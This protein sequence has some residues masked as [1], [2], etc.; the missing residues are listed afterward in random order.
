[1]VLGPVHFL[2]R[3]YMILTRNSKILKT[4]NIT[5]KIFYLFMSIKVNLSS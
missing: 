1:M 2:E 3:E 5:A 4:S